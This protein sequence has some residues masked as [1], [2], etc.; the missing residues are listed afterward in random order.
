MYDYLVLNEGLKLFIIGIA[1]GLIL[2]FALISLADVIRG[3]VE[4]AIGVKGRER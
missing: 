2:G 1:V 3:V 4:F